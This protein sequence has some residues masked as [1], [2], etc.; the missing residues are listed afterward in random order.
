MI[1]LYNDYRWYCIILF[2]RV[3]IQVICRLKSCLQC[4]GDL[5]WGKPQ[6]QEN[7]D[8]VDLKHWPHLMKAILHYYHHIIIIII[9]AIIN[10]KTIYVC[11]IAFSCNAKNFTIHCVFLFLPFYPVSQGN[12]ECF[13]LY[14]LL[15]KT[16]VTS[17]GVISLDTQKI[18]CVKTGLRNC[19]LRCMRPMT[20][21]VLWVIIRIH[22]IRK[23]IRNPQK[24]GN[25]ME[26]AKDSCW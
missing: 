22:N 11:L 17:T 13:L 8:L 19:Y 12:G 6:C 24:L 15:P 5:Q 10:A 14:S 23:R 9:I 7:S 2:I 4:I 26:D 21:H 3:W 25:K 18:V 1:L 16:C 20:W